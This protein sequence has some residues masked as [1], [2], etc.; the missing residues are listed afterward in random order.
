MKRFLLLISTLILTL[1]LLT[2]CKT[3]YNVTFVSTEESVTA[4]VDST[5]DLYIP[6]APDGYQ[7]VGWYLD[8]EFKTPVLSVRDIKGDVTLYARFIERGEYAVTFVWGNGDANTTVITDGTLIMPSDPEREQYSFLGWYTDEELTTSYEPTAPIASNLVLFAGWSYNPSPVVTFVYGIDSERITYKVDWG[9]EL[10]DYEPPVYDGYSFGG[11]YHNRA[12]TAPV[13]SDYRVTSSVILYARYIPCEYELGNLILS[14]NITSTVSV[15]TYNNSVFNSSATAGSGVIFA[16]LSGYY[17]ILTNEHVVAYEGLGYN[18]S[19]VVFD[20]Y[21]AEY[22]AELLASDKSYDL[23][24]VRVKKS[25]ELSVAQL[26]TEDE[27]VGLS[28]VS[29]GNPNGLINAVSYGRL[30]HYY[31]SEGDAL[32]FEVACHTAPIDHGSSGGAVFNTQ[33]ILVGINYAGGEDEQGNLY[34]FYIPITRVI[35]FLEANGFTVTD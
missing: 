3:S 6:T 30:L 9:F 34:S 1:L 2:S 29:V 26:A 25:A 10:K 31:D 14:R 24:V 4:S 35:E 33:G 7:F 16:E 27:A 21:G 17:Y 13:A 8:S 5:S 12:L 15:H 19:Y 28:V 22:D 23:A 11:W 32:E 18:V 20:A